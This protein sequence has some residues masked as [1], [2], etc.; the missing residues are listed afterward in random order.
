MCLLTAIACLIVILRFKLLNVP[1]GLGPFLMILFIVLSTMSYLFAERSKKIKK[2][3]ESA[4][5]HWETYKKDK[6]E[7]QEMERWLL[8]HQNN[9]NYD[10][11]KNQLE[12]TKNRVQKYESTITTDIYKYDCVDDEK[13]NVINTEPSDGHDFEYYC[14]DILRNNGFQNV[15]VTKGSGDQGVD[16]TAIKD[17]I[18]Y[19]F[20]CK[21]YSTA[22]GNAPVQEV[23]AG[24]AIYNCHVG[25]VMTNSTFTKGA[26]EAAEKTGVLLWD[27]NKINS[28]KW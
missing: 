28:M 27:G 10:I 26:I 18:R 9:S 2:K 7:I 15:L 8:K 12:R 22:L 6:A 14:A 4:K 11:V 13:S 5:S 17:G 25:V 20:Q 16:I 1:Y 3:L 21:H 24:K 23:Y 19:A